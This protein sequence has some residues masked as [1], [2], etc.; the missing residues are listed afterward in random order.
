MNLLEQIKNVE[1]ITKDGTNKVFTMYLNTDP[2]DPDQQGGKWKI[3][4]KNGLHNFER[5]L[6]EDA[7][8]EEL[9][10]FQQ[11]KKKV[12]RYVFDNEQHLK[13]S[14]VIFATADEAIWFAER[15]Q[16]RVKSEFYWE[17]YP[18]LEQL[19]SLI[20][21]YPKS[22]IILAHHDV[23]KVIETSCN[24]VEATLSYELDLDTEDWKEKVGPRKGFHSSGLGSRNAQIDN[25]KARFEANEH[26][27]YKSVA[28]KL[29][30]Q[31]KDCEW[32]KIYI[33]GEKDV[34]H[35]LEDAMNQ[36]ADEVI[37]KNMLE[38]EASKVIQAVFS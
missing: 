31:A 18:D 12:E 2:A 3:H 15:L 28:S 29:D 26:R 22:G 8:K 4:L 19:Q 23:V 21:E 38:Q 20:S 33:I 30:K 34:A 36:K 25:Y 27:W 13:K 6:K 1:K 24:E 5:Y 10:N 17:E 37:H 7:N 32:Q 11:I 16:I 14:I 9:K 35:A